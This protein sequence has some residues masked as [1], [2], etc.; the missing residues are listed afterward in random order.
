MLGQRALIVY[1]MYAVTR[2]MD[3][4]NIGEQSAI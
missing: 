1:T 2:S 3:V 4:L